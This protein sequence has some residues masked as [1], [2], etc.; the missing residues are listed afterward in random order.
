MCQ[1]PREAYR[2][3][4]GTASHVAW[5]EGP[6]LRVDAAIESANTVSASYDSLVAKIMAHAD[7]RPSA[8]ARLRRALIV[9]ELDQLETNRDLL[10]ALFGRRG[11]RPW[12]HRH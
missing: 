5:P 10:T 8:I 7:S 4:P 1:R 11:V 3:T 2:P 12:R 6:G 9:L